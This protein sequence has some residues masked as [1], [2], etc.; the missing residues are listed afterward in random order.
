[1]PFWRLARWPWTTSGRTM[2][3]EFIAQPACDGAA[4][5]SSQA[6]TVH[7][8]KAR[9]GTERQEQN[10]KEKASACCVGNDRGGGAG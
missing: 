3:R 8:A 7:P 9:D 5:L 4:V 2:K 1:V 6:D 10:V